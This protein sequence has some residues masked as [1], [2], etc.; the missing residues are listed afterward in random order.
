MKIPFDYILDRAFQILN[1]VAM[2][3]DCQDVIDEFYSYLDACGW[4]ETEFDAELLVRIN[5]SWD[6]LFN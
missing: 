5:N 4:T 1:L 6:I 3:D 2:I